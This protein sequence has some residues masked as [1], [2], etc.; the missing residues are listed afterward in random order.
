MTRHLRLA[1]L[2]HLLTTCSSLREALS[3]NVGLWAALLQREF[4]DGLWALQKQQQQ[5]GQPSRPWSW[6]EEYLHTH[7]V[8]HEVEASP[9][10]CRDVA[11]SV[12]FLHF[13]WQAVKFALTL[14]LLRSCAQRRQ[15]GR[16]Y[17]FTCQAQGSS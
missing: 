7:T 14:A 6:R 16:L 13:T 12:V 11:A 17:T 5:R 10:P 3:G 9:P 1:D 15:C 4:P 8:C 2:G